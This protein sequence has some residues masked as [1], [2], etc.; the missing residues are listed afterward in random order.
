LIINNLKKRLEKNINELLKAR[1]FSIDDND[2]AKVLNNF[3][4]SEP[5][6]K[7]FGDLSTNVSMVLAPVLRENPLVIARTIKEDIISNWDEVDSITIEKPGFIN[8]NFKDSFIKEE[9]KKIIT[10]KE[11]FGFNK[12]GQGTRIQLEY[13][14]S[15]PTGSLHIGHGRWGVLGDSLANIYSANGYN[16]FREYYVNDYGAQ[17]KNFANCVKCLYLRHFNIEIPYPEDG[18]PE[19]SV[20]IVVGKIIDK[21][22]DKFILHGNENNIV[23]A[24]AL[25]E[26]AVK[27]MVSH[28]MDTLSS[29]GVVFDR[30]FYEKDLYKDSNFEKVIGKLRDKNVIYEKDG[31]LWFKSSEFGDDKDRVVV[32]SDGNPT[33][34]AS[35]IL[36]LINKIE[37]GFGTLI[38][39][40][41]AD[42]HGYV[43][44]LKAV[45]KA[46]GIDE[47]RI[48]V[49]IGQL[50]RIMKSGKV[51]KMSRR[52][53]KVYTLRDLISEVGK[54][55]VRYFFCMN[56]FDTPMDFD[57]DLAKKR[58]NQNPVYYVQYTHARIES[59][60]RKIKSSTDTDIDNFNLDEINIS[61]MEFKT[62]TERDLAKAM[63]MYPDVIYNSCKNNSPYFVTQYLY[64]LASEF[65][66][67]YNH[68]RIIT[69]NKVNLNRLALLLLIKIVL[70][71]ALK[72]LNISAPEKM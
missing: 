20:S 72:M 48:A 12:S 1:S 65:H 43:K 46:L 45:G 68:Y 64:K 4:I 71:N 67:F 39:I 26:E 36:Y 54:D 34:F 16:V 13:V 5:K 62:K 56:S 63:I 59:I 38:Y 25:E 15:N 33:Y 61:E 18:Y 58:S 3:N 2:M 17:I 52:K 22:D 35:D 57:I 24:A 28:I 55:S 21:H 41:G 32:R 49:V 27:L 42:H 51:L 70:K 11:C 9:L 23:D 40:L 19:A 8:F 66:Y 14:S 47:G 50:V 30:W 53:G 31:A 60:I 69:K 10:E 29:I 44:R 37:R 6:N 7:D